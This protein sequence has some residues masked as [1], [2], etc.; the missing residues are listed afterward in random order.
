MRKKPFRINIGDV[1]IITALVL[2]IVIAVRMALVGA[3]Q[4]EYVIL[5]Q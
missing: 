3:G 1:I 4:I 2:M 5:R